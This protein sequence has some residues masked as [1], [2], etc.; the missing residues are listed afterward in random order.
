M[1]SKKEYELGLKFIISII[2]CAGM[3]SIPWSAL[4]IDYG[5]GAEIIYCIL[6]PIIF[7]ALFSLKKGHRRFFYIVAGVCFALFFLVFGNKIITGIQYLYDDFI[8]KSLAQAQEYSYY[9][10]SY[11]MQEKSLAML[12]FTIVCAA[13]TSAVVIYVRSFVAALINI[14]PLLGVFVWFVVIP[15]TFSFALCVIYIVSV[16]SL[17]GKRLNVTGSVA[18]MSIGIISALLIVFV[19]LPENYYERPTLFDKT[20]DMVM[21]MLGDKIDVNGPK[22]LSEKGTDDGNLGKIDRIQYKYEKV[23]SLTTISTGHT[24]YI[25]QY[26]GISYSPYDNEWIEEQSENRDYDYTNK[27]FKIYDA[28][29]VIRSKLDNASNEEY[30]DNYLAYQYTFSLITDEGDNNSDKKYETTQKDAFCVR[31]GDYSCFDNMEITRNNNSV[32]RQKLYNDYVKAFYVSVPADIQDMLKNELDGKFR[33]PSGE[34]ELEYAERIKEYF[35]DNYEYTLSPGAVPEGEDFISYFLTKSKKGYCTYFASAGVMI[36]RNAGIPA[37][38]CEGYIATDHQI[39]NGTP[40]EKEYVRYDFGGKTR[41]VDYNTYNVSI[42]DSAAHAWAEI[43]IQNYGWVPVEFTPGFDAAE[44]VYYDENGEPESE[45]TSE[46]DTEMTSSTID[47]QS[48]TDESDTES[49][50]EN[51]E[52]SEDI[53]VS[54]RGNSG[55]SGLDGR[56]LIIITGIIAAALSGGALISILTVKARKRNRLLKKSDMD[57]RQRVIGLYVYMNKLL[58]TLGYE[59]E[60]D[61]DY[62]D[63]ARKLEENDIILADFKLADAVNVALK[64]S[65][66]ED[67]ISAEDLGRMLSTVKKIREYALESVSP[68]KRMWLIVFRGM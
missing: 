10:F 12:A 8:E 7:V 31:S 1:N 38:Y 44:F 29:S 64:A 13:V 27:C 51:I 9:N 16:S 25:G 40:I 65:F 41:T 3:V 54:G 21:D 55:G 33:H 39:K 68:L 53:N 47:S 56:M 20:T 48:G 49:Y 18:L 14:V 59:K 19:F 63:Y 23:A 62:E 50:S 6:F 2:G 28:N 46:N 5:I 34:S 36:L 11:G 4:E 22:S 61:G 57:N 32:S 66:S 26:V 30:Y 15:S 17:Y 45:S 43:F 52:S 37:R 42:N 35:A 60:S 58:L 67:D 24:Q